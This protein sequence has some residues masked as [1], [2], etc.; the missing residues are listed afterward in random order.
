[1][2][3][4]VAAPPGPLQHQ[5]QL[6]AHPRLAD[7]L[8]QVP[9]PQR[10]LDLDVLRLRG[11]RQLA[12]GAPARVSGSGRSPGPA[13]AAVE[14]GAQ[15]RCWRRRPGGRARSSA[16]STAAS[17]GLAVKP[18][19]DQRLHHLRRGAG[20]RRCSAAA[21]AAAGA[22]GAPTLSLSSSTMP[23]GHLGPDARHPGQRLDLAA[24]Q[25]AAQRVRV[26]HGEHGQRQPRP[27]PGHRL[28]QREQLALARRRRTRTGS[29]S[30]P[31]PPA[32]WPAGPARRGA[33]RPA[34]PGWRARPARPR[35]PRPRRGPGRSDSTS[36]RTELIIVPPG[37]G[38]A[39]GP[40]RPAG[41][42]A[43]GPAR[44]SGPGP[45]PSGPA[46]G[47][48]NS[49]RWPAPARRRRRPGAGPAASPSSRVTMAVT[50]SLPARPCPVTAA[51]TSLGVWKRDRQPGPR[52]EQ[53][54][55]PAG[56][57]GAHHGAHVALAEHP[58]DG[59]H[60]R[61]VPLRST[62]RRRSP[63]SAQPA[64]DR[65]VGRGAHDVDGH[66][67][68]RPA[69][70]AVDHAEAA[71]GQ[72]RVDAEHPHPRSLPRTAV[73]RAEATGD[74]AGRPTGA[75]PAPGE[76]PC[77]VRAALGCTDRRRPLPSDHAGSGGR[78]GGCRGD[79]V[80]L[81]APRP[82]R[83][84]HVRG[85]VH[86]IWRRSSLPAAPGVLARRR[87]RGTSWWAT[88]ATAPTGIGPAYRFTVED[89][90]YVQPEAT[91]GGSARGCW[92]A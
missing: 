64:L 76:H 4:R 67:A 21:G 70:A 59:H 11:R 26:E 14:G 10:G 49:G 33:A 86:P 87:G 60:V 17:A 46:S 90:V 28:Q 77:P 51:L 40:P 55:H 44:P 27:D 72:P 92:P 45:G 34:W 43:R 36:P 16:A 82:A 81:R 74:E 18:E 1:M 91:G 66:A 78:A 22:A 83:R 12:H 32:W 50:C 3:G 56:L 54:D 57:R 7:E 88:R 13:Q 8:A 19:P 35:R 65:Q 25:R 63:I 6:L 48:A 61:P 84:G 15:Q 23:L 20:C 80:D 53:R 62:P 85:G 38:A 30:P 9:R 52:G 29:A 71:P 79:T 89:S 24:G 68:D 41:P 69:A 58:L 39:P 37:H 73:R 42:G 5:L 2:V 47:P 75:P 31:A